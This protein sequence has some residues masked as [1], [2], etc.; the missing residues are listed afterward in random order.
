MKTYHPI[1][2]YFHPFETRYAVTLRAYDGA[3]ATGELV[4]PPRD[5]EYARLA[6]RLS[7][8]DL[9]PVELLRLGATLYQTLFTSQFKTILS[10]TRAQLPP[11]ESLRL[12]LHID[13]ERIRTPSLP[14]C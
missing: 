7:T 6:A 12:R 5:S 1:D 8:D 4:L 3:N 2:L 9:S 13:V 14:P 11:S 10:N